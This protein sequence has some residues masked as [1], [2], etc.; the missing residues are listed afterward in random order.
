MWRHQQIYQ[1]LKNPFKDQGKQL[2][3]LTTYWKYV[4]SFFNKNQLYT[5]TELSVTCDKE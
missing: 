1:N 4:M 2:T 3:V 5:L